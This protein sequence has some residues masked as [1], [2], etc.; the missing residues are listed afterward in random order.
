M[1]QRN[2]LMGN[3]MPN[4]RNGSLWNGRVLGAFPQQRNEEKERMARMFDSVARKARKVYFPHFPHPLP[5]PAARLQLRL[6]A[7]GRSNRIIPL[8][9]NGTRHYLASNWAGWGKKL[10]PNAGGIWNNLPCPDVGNWY[11]LF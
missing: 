1:A 10:T 7:D 3:G 9:W 11:Y 4:L 8:N 5:H 2:N 6:C